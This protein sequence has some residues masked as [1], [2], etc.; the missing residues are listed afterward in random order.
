MGSHEGNIINGNGVSGR[1]MEISVL[2]LGTKNKYKRMDS[3]LTDGGD[4]DLHH[5]A[6]LENRRKTTRK[7][8]FA[9]A[10]F[11]SLN[12]VL[13]GYGKISVFSR[14]CVYFVQ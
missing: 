13:L 9:C 1:D 8:V 5:Q 4:D 10:V 7:F 3:Q 6:E 14:S 2:P 11:A 12:N